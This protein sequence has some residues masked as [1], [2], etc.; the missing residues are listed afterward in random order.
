MQIKVYDTVSKHERVVTKKAFDI[1]NRA[2]RKAPRYEV[3]EYLDDDGNAINQPQS[4]QSLEEIP[5]VEKK[6]E[7]SVAAPAADGETVTGD[8]DAQNFPFYLSDETHET[9]TVQIE[10]QPKPAPKK[11]GRKPKNKIADA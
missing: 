2:R 1:I 10:H 4:L 11:R 7:E 6:T 8:P 3:I 5:T 9:P